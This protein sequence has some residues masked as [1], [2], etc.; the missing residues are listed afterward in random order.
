M[1]MGCLHSKEVVVVETKDGISTFPRS[2]STAFSMNAA[3]YVLDGLFEYHG[4]HF[5]AF[6]RR[7]IHH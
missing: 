7:F 4:W 1:R 3:I 2:E 5:N 6:C